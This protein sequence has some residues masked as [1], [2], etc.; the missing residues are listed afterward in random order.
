MSFDQEQSAQLHLHSYQDNASSFPLLKAVASSVI[1]VIT[2]PADLALAVHLDKGFIFC[3][4]PV[5][6]KLIAPFNERATGEAP[7]LMPFGVI[8]ICAALSTQNT[9]L[10]VRR[11]LDKP[12]KYRHQYQNYWLRSLALIILPTLN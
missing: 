8:S 4:D 10:S 12:D 2:C 9:L 3:P 5:L 6:S 11:S 1:N 7:I